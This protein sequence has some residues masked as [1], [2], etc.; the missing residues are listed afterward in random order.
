M[1]LVGTHQSLNMESISEALVLQYP[2]FRGAPPIQG[3][4]G[5]GKGKDGNN[6]AAPTSS[7]SS[8]N[9]VN[10]AMR[11]PQQTSRVYVAGADEATNQVMESIGEGDEGADD[12]FDNPHQ[13]DD[14]L[15][16]RERRRTTCRRRR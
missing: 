4:K 5:I 6:V 1:V 16:G 15:D 10:P 13:D 9:R 7:S 14:E 2:D 11:R 3:Q 8:T 12:D